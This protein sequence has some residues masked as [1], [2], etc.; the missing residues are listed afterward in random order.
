MTTS[1]P[2][3]PR[4]SRPFLVTPYV[5][6]ASGTVNA[7]MP[8]CCPT[9]ADAGTEG[10]CALARHHLRARKTGPRHPL[11]VVECQAHGVAFTLYPPGYAPFR[12][13]AVV[14]LAPDGSPVMPADESAQGA[15]AG[16]VFEAAVDAEAGRRWARE[17]QDEV[18][19]RWWSTQGRHLHLLARLVGVANDITD[20]V[21]ETIAAT[22]SVGMMTLRDLCQGKGYRAIGR[23][24]MSVLSLLEGGWPRRAQQ[25]LGCG[26]HIGQWGEPMHWDA[27]RQALVR[28]PF[29]VGGTSTSP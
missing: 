9:K 2:S 29:S 11:A 1:Y 3:R 12:R 6:D 25:L 19:E 22:L 17:T 27:T 24:V 7:V 14:K 23:A 8:S 26:H 21:R 13:Q 18:P 15:F 16:T 20:K 28:S 10:T 4:S 5:T